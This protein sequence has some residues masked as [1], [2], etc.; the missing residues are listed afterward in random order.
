MVHN[1]KVLLPTLC[2]V[3]VEDFLC[4]VIS[5]LLDDLHKYFEQYN[6]HLRD[7]TWRQARSL[8]AANPYVGHK[9]LPLALRRSTLC[10][11]AL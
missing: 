3:P 8:F 7:C 5:L 9:L 2:R 6:W 11:D 4:L 10:D 1:V